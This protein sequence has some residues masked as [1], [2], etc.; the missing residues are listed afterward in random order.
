MAQGSDVVVRDG[1]AP[2]QII[3][4]RD[5]GAFLVTCAAT[6]AVG[7]FDGVGPFAPTAS[8]LAEI[9]PPRMTYRLV[10]VDSAALSAA[11]ITLP[12]MWMIHT[13]PSSPAVLVPSP[14]RPASRLTAQPRPPRRSGSGKTA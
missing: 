12:M 5:L 3:D 9:A 8:L 10:E 6:R 1:S 13:T 11:G 14:E 4:V 7:A 2:M